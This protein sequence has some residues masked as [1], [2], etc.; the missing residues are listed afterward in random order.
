V[1][2]SLKGAPAKHVTV[3]FSPGQ[4]ESPAFAP[5]EVVLLFLIETGPG[6][7]Q[8]T[9]GEQGKFTFGKGGP[10]HPV[11]RPPGPR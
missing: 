11:G 5:E 3:A 10:A 6:R 4:S 1:E 7:Y 8:T 9:G 2:C